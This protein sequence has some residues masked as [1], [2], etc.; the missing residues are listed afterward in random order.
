MIIKLACMCAHS[1]PVLLNLMNLAG[2]DP[3][4]MGFFQARILEC[5]AI[6][7]CQGIF[8][9]QLSNPHPL[10]FLRWQVDSL[11][12]SHLVKLSM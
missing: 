12:M 11:P 6:P 3:L 9:I 5:I 7:P 8:P 1:C 10:H 2:Q 4:S